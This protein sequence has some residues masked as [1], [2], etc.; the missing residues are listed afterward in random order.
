MPGGAA[1]WSTKLPDSET[2]KT[3]EADGR[4]FAEHSHEQLVAK[5]QWI[6]G[7]TPI[8]VTAA[9]DAATSPDEL[10]RGRPRRGLASR[11]GKKGRTGAPRISIMFPGFIARPRRK[12]DINAPARVRRFD[13]DEVVSV[14]VMALARYAAGFSPEAFD[15]S[16]PQPLAVITIKS[17]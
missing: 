13:D 4:S 8:T 17:A 5:L 12:T 15:A 6:I 10:C 1:C 14:A 2:Y 7:L 16:T 9:V 3:I 11:S